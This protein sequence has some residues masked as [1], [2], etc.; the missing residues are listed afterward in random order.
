M[1][2]LSDQEVA[3]IIQSGDEDNSQTPTY[4]ELLVALPD[5]GDS[6]PQ[7]SGVSLPQVGSSRNGCLSSWIPRW[8]T[9][10][11]KSCWKVWGR[12][13][14]LPNLIET[15]VR[16]SAGVTQTAAA[17]SADCL[18]EVMGMIPDNLQSIFTGCYSAD[19]CLNKLKAAR[20]QLINTMSEWVEDKR[21]TIS[22]EGTQY[23]DAMMTGAQQL[24]DEMEAIASKISGAA[25]ALGGFFSDARQHMGNIFEEYGDIDDKD[26]CSSNFPSFE[27]SD[28]GAFGELKTLLANLHEVYQITGRFDSVRSKLSSCVTKTFEVGSAKVPT[29]FMDISKTSKCVPQAMRDPIRGIVAALRYAFVNRHAAAAGLASLV[30][31]VQSIFGSFSAF[32]RQRLS[33]LALL[34]GEGESETCSDFGAATV[35]VGFSPR[36]QA[37][38]VALQGAIAIQGRLTCQ[39]GKLT[40]DLLVLGGV[41]FDLLTSKP[42][43]IKK[44]GSV[45]IAFGYSPPV[46]NPL[47]LPSV[48]MG[49]VSGGALMKLAA[50]GIPCPPLNLPNKCG[51]GTSA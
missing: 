38:A 42:L 27:I 3:A 39:G 8:C 44:T 15:V 2:R 30:S 26:F 32:L 45:V 21:E 25:N 40:T 36:M 24:M 6:R 51:G 41:D 10:M 33:K 37:T 46:S 18:K 50:R 13:V 17:T 35:E 14:C 7:S 48:K 29:P 19:S 28:C 20:E 34:Q 49:A 11:R 5:A 43:A 4:E 47:G 31:D 12:Q 23:V 1:L 22:A 16:C 9:E